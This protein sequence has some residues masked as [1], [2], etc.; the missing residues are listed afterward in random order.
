MNYTGTLGATVY[1]GISRLII[2]RG[3][4]MALRNGLAPPTS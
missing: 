3:K 2:P 1:M 4:T